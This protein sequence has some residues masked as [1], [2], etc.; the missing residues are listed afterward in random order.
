MG[1]RQYKMQSIKEN[2]KFLT[3][4][5]IFKIIFLELKMR[6]KVKQPP[7]V[8]SKTQPTKKDDLN[9]VF[10][11]DCELIGVD[12]GPGDGYYWYRDYVAKCR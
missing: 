12:L 7:A 8:L 9:Y 6:W 5:K 10:F 1:E 11:S 4:K 2:K 3:Q